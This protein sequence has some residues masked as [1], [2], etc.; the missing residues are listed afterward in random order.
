MLVLTAGQAFADITL[1]LGPDGNP[2][3]NGASRL[4]VIP[5]DANTPP[6]NTVL[7]VGGGVTPPPPVTPPVP[8]DTLDARLTL[9]LAA[10]DDPDRAVTGGKLKVAYEMTLQL[11]ANSITDA[12]SLRGVMAGIEKGVLDSMKKTAGW[13]PWT[14][15]LAEIVKPMDFAQCLTTYK[16]AA[17]KLGGGPVPPPPPPPPPVTTAVKAVILRESENQTQ[18]QAMMFNQ[19]RNDPPWSKLVEILDP[20]QQTQD[21]QPDP[22]AQAAAVASRGQIPSLLLLDAGGSF[23]GE[24]M[25]LPENFDALKAALTAKGVKP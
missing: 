17:A 16:A 22:L 2:L 12:N 3:P 5:S 14:A 1:L 25:P 7:H 9:L 11:T 18:P 10:V 23:V 19:L 8:P 20:N 6:V 24:P 21:K 13:Q 15:G 4:L